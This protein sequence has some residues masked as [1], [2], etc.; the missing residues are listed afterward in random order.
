[1]YVIERFTAGPP[2]AARA[3]ALVVHGLNVNPKMMAAIVACLSAGGIEAISLALHGHG[4]NYLRRPDMAETEA[5]L[6]SLRRVTYQLWHDEVLAA[7]RI[8][9]QR[10]AQLEGAPVYLVAYSLG[11]L[12]AC[13]LFAATPGVEFA[14]MVLF[15]PAL[16]IRPLSYLLAP[17]QGAPR[18]IIPSF[19]PK[20]YRAN[21]GTSLAAYAALYAA[22]ANLARHASS[23]INVPTLVFLD[24]QDELVSYAGTSR[25]L[26]DASLTNWRLCPVEKDSTAEQ[27]YHHLL[28]DAASVGQDRWRAMSAAVSAH[29]AASGSSTPAGD[30]VPTL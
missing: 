5:R 26:R 30:S 21:R 9:A 28:I 11:G 29:L 23:K 22:A 17:F 2:R 20:S 27:R 1:M 16:R 6:E 25:F 24:P 12:M 13:D 8:V 14:R 15:A 4:P 3:V 7:Y 19:S 18:T 10:A